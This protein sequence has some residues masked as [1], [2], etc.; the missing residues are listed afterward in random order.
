MSCC[1]APGCERI[2]DRKHASRELR[3]YRKN[4]P[5]ATTQALIQS[6]LRAGVK[7]DTV[8]DIGGGVGAIQYDLLKAGARTAV[9]VDASSAFEAAARGEA[10]RQGLSDR[11]KYEAGDFVDLADQIAPADIVTLD[12][13]VCCYPN[14]EALVRLSAQHSRRIYGLVYPR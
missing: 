13:V 7:D 4:G 11:I 8:L 3:N 5:I 10:K 9:S 12:R 2:F 6:V 14:M 1:G